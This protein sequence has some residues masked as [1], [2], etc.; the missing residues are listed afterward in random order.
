MTQEK[1]KQALLNELDT[2]VHLRITIAQ[3]A[4]DEAKE[5]KE[6][7]T[8][9]TA[10][11][12]HEVGRA[13]MQL[14]QEKNEMQLAK[15]KILESILFQINASTKNSK[16]CFGSLIVTN[17]GN[18]FLSIGLGKIEFGNKTYYT[19]SPESPIAKL[20]YNQRIGWK[21]KFREQSIEILEIH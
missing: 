21:G 17:V 3:K 9:S 4:I 2:K 16:V 7:E 15:A 8:K 10:G 18:Y 5:S 12:K 6:Q 20:M 11:D 1:L 13:M 19:I 14:E